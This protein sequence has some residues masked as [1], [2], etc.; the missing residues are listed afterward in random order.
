MPSKLVNKLLAFYGAQVTLLC[1]HDPTNRP[2]PEPVEFGSH[3]P[4]LCY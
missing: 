4:I 3:P 1:S 2:Y